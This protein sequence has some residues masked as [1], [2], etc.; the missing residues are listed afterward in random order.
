MYFWAHQFQ[1][2]GGEG[3]YLGLQTKGNRADGSLGKMA[4]FSIWDAVEAEGPGPDKSGTVRFTGEGTG[5]SCRIPYHWV[6]GD[7]Y[8]LRVATDG[9][10]WWAATVA[11]ERSGVVSPIGRIRVPGEWRGLGCWSVMWTEYYGAP[12]RRCADLAHSSAVFGIP[13][14]VDEGGRGVVPD[15][16][17]DHL[18]DGRCPAS[19]EEVDGGVR[20]EMGIPAR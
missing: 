11:D 4:I 13:T 16:R 20:Q 10:G 3:G 14:A 5:W 12:L 17:H 2:D 9:G 7:A 6:A 1:L 8:R 18:S 19:V 15:R